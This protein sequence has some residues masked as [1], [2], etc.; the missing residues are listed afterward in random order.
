MDSKGILHEPEGEVY[1]PEEFR[2]GYEEGILRA[3]K[4][5]HNEYGIREGFDPKASLDK[6][7]PNQKLFGAEKVGYDTAVSNYQ[8]A[9]ELK[10]MMMFRDIK[11]NLPTPSSYDRLTEAQ[12]EKAYEIARHAITVAFVSPNPEESLKLVIEQYAKD[13][14]YVL[15][16]A[17]SILQRDLSFG[18]NDYSEEERR[19]AL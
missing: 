14:N 6:V 16:V 3:N 12:R 9:S 19:Q 15:N 17:A 18:T 7:M 5:G 8:E 1:N 2:I 13:P 4:V 10:K 11:A